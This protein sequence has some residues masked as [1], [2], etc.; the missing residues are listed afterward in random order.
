MQTPMPPAPPQGG[1]PMPMPADPMAGGPPPATADDV[2][3]AQQEADAA[4]AAGQQ[5]D[6]PVPDES[7]PLDD[8]EFV[9]T[10]INDV[11]GAV[12]KVIGEDAVPPL[13]WKKDF[14]ADPGL[15]ES[16]PGMA[17]L[18]GMKNLDTAWP[19]P[20]WGAAKLLSTAPAQIDGGKHK[21]L[22]FDAAE[23]LRTK[24]GTKSA[25]AKL[26][27]IAKS[28]PLIKALAA[29]EQG[30]PVPENLPPVSP[31]GPAPIGSDLAD[32]DPLLAAV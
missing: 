24:G 19:G 2:M 8:V 27:R 28:K 4:S 23:L 15:A 29:A 12:N 32:D 31:A 6:A 26:K 21:A 13:P 9:V 16:L 5:S 30:P 25:A 11:V 1:A 17:A 3:A 22:A 18:V 20:I 14:E 10:A 7:I